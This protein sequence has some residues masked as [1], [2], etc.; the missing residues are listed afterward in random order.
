MMLTAFEH[1]EATLSTLPLPMIPEKGGTFPD[2]L[3]EVKWQLD[4]LLTTQGTDGSVSFKVTAKNFEQFVM[5]DQ[6]GA[7]R[8]YTPVSTSA[9]AD[10]AAALAQASRV[11]RPYDGALADTYLAA[12]RQAYAF[13]KAN[14]LIKPDVT[15]F[16]TGNYDANSGDGDNRMWAAAELW[17]TTGEAEFLTDFEAAPGA[18]A[19][20]DNFDWDNVGNLG[21]FTYL[22]SQR[23]GRD[24]AKVDLLTASAIASANA[25][26]LRADAAAFG[27]GLTNYWWG[28]NGA[29]ARLAM[30]L[31]VG[32][33]LSPADAGR[34]SDAIAMQ[35]DHLLGRNIYDRTQVTGVGYHP[36]NK[37]HHRPSEAD[38]VGV[39]WPGLMVGGANPDADRN[40]LPAL[41]WKDNADDYDLN[42]VA[43]NWNAPLIYAAAALTPPL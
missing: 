11:Y 14:G 43:I 5:P 21:M 38:N 6:D 4:W 25:I 10:F 8:Y 19:V 23:T 26:A 9:T 39:A 42:E 2:F 24:Q 30:N 27:R 32:G 33:V 17:E 41:T 35:L 7:Q 28:S 20:A 12:A 3:D 16:G 31:W 34:F 22:L 18:V 37:P 29:V 13:L 15:M 36:P 1:F 40:V